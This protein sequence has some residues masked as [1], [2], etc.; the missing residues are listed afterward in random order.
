MKI[1]A[2]CAVWTLAFCGVLVSPVILIFAVPL[3]IGVGIDI[4]EWSATPLAAV[5]VVGSAALLTLCKAPVR[6]SIKTLV[7][8]AAPTRKPISAS[9]APRHAAKSIS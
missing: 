8:P 6:G 2:H 9:A 3:A 1:V 5:F 4:A 7:R